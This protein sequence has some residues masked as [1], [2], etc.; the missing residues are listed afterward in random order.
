MIFINDFSRKFEIDLYRLCE[1]SPYGARIISYHMAYHGQKYNFLDFWIQR[2]ENGTPTCAFCR[3]YSTLIIC[4]TAS[5]IPEIE[6]FV[7]MIMPTDILCEKNLSIKNCSA[8]PA[9]EVM[10]CTQ[11]NSVQPFKENDFSIK[12]VSSDMRS[13]RKIY[14]I[15]HNQADFAELLPDF[16]EYFLDISHRIRHGTSKIYAI[17]DLFENY[18]STAAIIAI[19]EKSAV[20]GSVATLADFRNKGFATALV[21]YA[22]AEELKNGR[23][24][25]LHRKNNITI[26]EK[27][28]FSKTE[29]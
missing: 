1:C 25:Y 8:A 18:I 16:E 15:L 17:T 12:K 9:G 2:D 24:V 27:L 23:T 3:Y 4:G 13:L 10:I 5:D 6:S 19:S 22:T 7:S 20:I 26:Y 28:G 29:I 14:N 11:L 21:H